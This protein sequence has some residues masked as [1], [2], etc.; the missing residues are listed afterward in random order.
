MSHLPQDL[1][2]IFPDDEA[3]LRRLKAEDRHFR[4][5]ADRYAALDQEIGQIGLGLEPASDARTEELKKARLHVLDELA[6]VLAEARG[7]A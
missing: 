7:A 4:A 6:A 3:L 5:L 1:H 2:D